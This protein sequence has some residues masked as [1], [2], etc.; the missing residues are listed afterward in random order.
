MSYTFF[1]RERLI[2]ADP[3]DPRALRRVTLWDQIAETLG[4]PDFIAIVA[5]CVIGLL[6]T[7]AFS[8]GFPD[9]GC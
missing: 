7:I 3:T 4:S 6:V 8:F 2:F 1:G 5:F 9:C